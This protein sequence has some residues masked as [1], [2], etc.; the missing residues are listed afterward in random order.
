MIWFV[1]FMLLYPR[2]ENVVVLNIIMFK[3]EVITMPLIQYKNYGS[4]NAYWPL[5]L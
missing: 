3:R 5:W 2:L 4:I 1:F